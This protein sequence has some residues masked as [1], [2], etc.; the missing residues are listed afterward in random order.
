MREALFVAQFPVKTAMAEKRHG[1][2]MHISGLLESTF[3][4]FLEKG[5]FPP[6]F[7]PRLNPSSPSAARGLH[8]TRLV[9]PNSLSTECCLAVDGGQQHS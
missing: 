4:N 1:L 9:S 5:R 8:E 6:Q 3:P 2:K 7:Q